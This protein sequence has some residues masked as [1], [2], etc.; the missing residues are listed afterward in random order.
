MTMTMTEMLNAMT[1]ERDIARANAEE[2]RDAANEAAEEAERLYQ[3]G[4]GEGCDEQDDLCLEYL[5]DAHEYE[6]CEEAWDNAIE[7]LKKLQDA[8]DELGRDITIEW[9]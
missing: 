5:K 1:Q 4:D 2:L 3:M 6:G 8:M 7:A 9:A